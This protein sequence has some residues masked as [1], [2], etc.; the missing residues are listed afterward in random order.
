MCYLASEQSRERQ[1]W[2]KG[3]NFS[4]QYPDEIVRTDN[5]EKEGVEVRRKVARAGNHI[6]RRS[7]A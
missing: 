6:I 3:T 7:R 4:A 2:R 1:R 5:F